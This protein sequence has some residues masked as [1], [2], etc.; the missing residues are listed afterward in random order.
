MPHLAD[1]VVLV[2]EEELRPA[3]VREARRR[4][5]APSGDRA[6]LEGFGERVRGVLELAMDLPRAPLAPADAPEL[7]READGRH[8]EEDVG[9]RKQVGGQ[10]EKW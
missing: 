9:R 8:R 3:K 10:A 1:A 7:E 6:R 2:E 4:F 5:V